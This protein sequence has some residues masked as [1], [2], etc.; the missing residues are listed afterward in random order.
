MMAN[1]F[2]CLSSFLAR[3]FKSL[4]V[5]VLLSQNF[6]FGFVYYASLYYL[7]LY[8]QTARRWDELESAA[9]VVP[10][11]V[12]QSVTSVLSGQYISKGRRYGEVLWFGYATWTLAAGLRCLFGRTTPPVAI[13]FI[14]LLEGA[15]V[16]CTF[17]PSK[18]LKLAAPLEPV[19]HLD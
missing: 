11:V 9:L 14:L 19:Q 16:G 18:F 4:A 17:Q 15:G 6:L 13:V 2:S 10:I 5:S 12:G 1:P 7:P 8:Y 3:L